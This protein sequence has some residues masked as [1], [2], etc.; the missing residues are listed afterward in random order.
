MLRGLWKLTWIELK[1][2]AREP[3]GLI[4]SIAMPVLVFV[5]LGRTAGGDDRIR[6]TASRR[7]PSSCRC[8]RRF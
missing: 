4:A 6:P 5:V 3:L 2:F 1:I 8:S 7:S